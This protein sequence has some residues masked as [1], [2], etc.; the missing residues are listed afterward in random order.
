MKKASKIALGALALSLVPFELK[1]GKDGSFSYQ[2]LLLGISSKKNEEGKR[3]LV[4]SL[5]NV[6]DCLKKKPAQEASEEQPEESAEA[7]E[8]PAEEAPE[9]AAPV[10]EPQSDEP[11]A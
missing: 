4:L 2:S 5:F 3:N 11:T 9:A 6:P 7:E 8:T 10:E 1:K